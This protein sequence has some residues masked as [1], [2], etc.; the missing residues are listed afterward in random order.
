VNQKIL[1]MTRIISLVLLTVTL[2]GFIYS[3]VFGM[4]LETYGNLY[5]ELADHDQNESFKKTNPTLTSDLW[6]YTAGDL[7]LRGSE[8]DTLLQFLVD[9]KFEGDLQDSGHTSPTGYFNQYYM[10]IPF[11]ET[12]FLYCG[13][14]YKQI[15]V[16]KFFNISNRYER[17]GYPIKLIEYDILKSDSFNYGFVTNFKGASQWDQVQYSGFIDLSLNNFNMQAYRFNEGTR[18]YS[19]VTDLTYQAG[20]YQFYGEALWMSQADQKVARIQDI[21]LKPGD[22]SGD[23]LDYRDQNSATKILAGIMINQPNYSITLEFM[24]NNEAYNPQER[25]NFISYLARHPGGHQPYTDYF[26]YNWA[27]NYLGLRWY[28]P[29]LGSNECSLTNSII[30]SLPDE[31]ASCDYASY[32]AYSN[33][34]YNIY[35]N[36]TVN[37]NITYH[38]GGSKGEY[39]N[40]YEDTTRYQVSLLYSF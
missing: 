33:I 11:H 5:L 39:L 7:F 21:P 31:G 17:A 4:G 18:G 14:K 19:V 25:D 34:A 13:Q 8:E 16:A 15:G 23:S 38:F 40:L 36:L 12:T 26:S 9:Y 28:L 32:Q 30:A 3:P 37:F 6:T 10:I 24:K 20:I 22:T 2:L 29:K 27:Q 35:Q 1:F